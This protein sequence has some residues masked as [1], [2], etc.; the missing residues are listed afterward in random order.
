MNQRILC[1]N[2][3]STS[4]KLAVF[5]AGALRFS[6]EVRHRKEDITAC[7]GVQGQLSLRRLAVEQALARHGCADAPGGFDAVAGRGGLLRPVPGGV[8]AVDE[9]MLT[10][11][12]QNAHGEH[13]CN[14]GAPLALHFAKISGCPAYVMDPPVTDEL[15]GIARITGLPRIRRRSVFHALSQ[16]MAAR[17]A[18]E[19][20]GLVYEDAKFLVAHLG[21]GVSVGAHDR[22]RVVD[23]TNGVDGE[24]PMSAERAGTLPAL[25]LVEMVQKG[26]DPARLRREILTCGGL[27]AHAGTNDL[28]EVEARFRAGDA[29]CGEIISALAYAVAKAVGSMTAALFEETEDGPAAVVLTGGMARSE[30]LVAEITRRV[31]FFAPVLALPQVDEMQALAKGAQLA[32]SGGAPVQ[33]YAALVQG[34]GV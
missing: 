13:P 7:G 5:E 3:G 25:V 26:A 8:Y 6:E 24:G 14:L 28:R 21:G 22:G 17:L 29:R 19:Q 32:L 16:R 34:A 12:A 2:P 27:Y 4:T 11:L 18:A 30:L 1:I 9:V 31:R 33:S 20:L 23:V 15:R 10:E